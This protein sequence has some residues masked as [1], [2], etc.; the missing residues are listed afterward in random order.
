MYELD[1]GGDGDGDGGG[2]SPASAT[3]GMSARRSTS[4]SRS[5]S[6]SSAVTTASI[7][8]GRAPGSFASIDSTKASTGAG[9]DGTC[10]R[11]GRTA[12]FRWAEMISPKP[13]NGNG[14]A[15]VS[16]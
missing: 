2:S 11:I 16:A 13:W 8:W 15:P 7:V 5:P 1:M 14:G 9:T 12:V 6:W 10:D 3:G 4:G